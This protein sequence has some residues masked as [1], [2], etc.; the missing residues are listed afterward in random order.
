MF[1]E[2]VLTRKQVKSEDAFLDDF[3]VFGV[4][5]GHSAKNFAALC[6]DKSDPVSLGRPLDWATW[7]KG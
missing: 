4:E 2:E 1:I 5:T 3:Q 7:L 6:P